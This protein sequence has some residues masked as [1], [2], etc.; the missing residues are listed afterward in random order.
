MTTDNSECCGNLV[1]V[2]PELL[3]LMHGAGRHPYDTTRQ[4]Q[5]R[6]ERVRKMKHVREF[7][8]NVK[9]FGLNC[10]KLWG[11]FGSHWPRSWFNTL[12]FQCRSPFSFQPREVYASLRTCRSPRR[13]RELL[14]NP[15]TELP[16][17]LAHHWPSDRTFL[18][19]NSSRSPSFHQQWSLSQAVL[20]EPPATLSLENGTLLPLPWGV[21]QAQA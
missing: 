13:F 16:A 7:F 1:I 20:W 15:A 21:Y 11:H 10:G 3:F 5:D 4:L 8:E 6:E 19:I 14:G 17:F 18:P 9:D 12:L 2:S